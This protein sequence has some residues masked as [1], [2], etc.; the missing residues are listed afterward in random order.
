[1]ETCQENINTYKIVKQS[2]E[3]KTAKISSSSDAAKFI[4]NFYF[5]DIEVFESF[6]I[7]FLNRANDVEGYVKI[8]QGGIVGS[9]VD[10]KILCK[11][12]LDSL[13]QSVILTHNH[14]SGNTQP[15]QADKNITEKVKKA[16]QLFEISVLDH[17]IISKDS[18]LSFAD[19]GIL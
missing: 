7:M 15:S 17:I 11:Y 19:E 6:F 1:M 5:E 13:C 8:S 14:P 9:V 12:A 3:I 10:V 2:T 4:R 16:L 18:Y